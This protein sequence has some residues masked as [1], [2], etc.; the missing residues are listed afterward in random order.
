MPRFQPWSEVNCASSSGPGALVG[1]DGFDEV[2]EAWIALSRAGAVGLPSMLNSRPGS[3]PPRP[4]GR[5]RRRPG[6]AGI[7]TRM[8]R[9]ARRAG[10]ENRPCAVDDVGPVAAPGIA[11]PGDLLTLT[12]NTVMRRLRLRTSSGALR[13]TPRKRPSSAARAVVSWRR[14]RQAA[15]H[16]DERHDEPGHELVVHPGVFAERVGHPDVDRARQREYAGPAVSERSPSPVGQHH[17]LAEGGAAR[18]CPGRRIG[19]R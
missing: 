16:Q 4:S 5:R 17:H 15:S 10:V 3:R 6:Y 19:C 7:R 1:P 14:G 9:D 2:I 13:R 18:S 8:D 11:Q 12:D